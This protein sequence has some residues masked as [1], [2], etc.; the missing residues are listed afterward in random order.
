VSARRRARKC[1]DTLDGRAP[2]CGVAVLGPQEDPTNCWTLD[3][4]LDT[5]GVPAQVLDDLGSYQA[6]LFDANPQGRGWQ[7]IA[8]F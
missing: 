6:T 8:L 3:M 5:R 2:V 7:A 4:T 1:A